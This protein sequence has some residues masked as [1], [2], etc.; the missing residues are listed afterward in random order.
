MKKAICL[1]T[2]FLV[3][4]SL[5]ACSNE[6]KNESSEKPK[7]LNSEVQTP[8]PTDSSGNKAVEDKST[9]TEKKVEEEKTKT[10]GYVPSNKQ[11]RIK[12][13]A[14]YLTASSAATRLD[15]YIQ[16]ANKT[17][18]NAYVIDYKNDKGFVY[19]D[20]EVQEAIDV[21]A[22]ETQYKTKEV[23]AKFKKN[24]IYSVAR[25]GNVSKDPIYSKKDLR[26]LSKI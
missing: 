10:D 7:D 3:S 17:E 26:W 24:N 12:A 8:K 22:V 6:I 13:K 1:I 4:V 25:I 15:H 11:K 14:L 21:G 5:L 20:S 9:D 2:I 16:L 18:I 23:T 19:A